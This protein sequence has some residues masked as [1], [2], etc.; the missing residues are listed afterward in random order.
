MFILL[1]QCVILIN[2]QQHVLITPNQAHPLDIEPLIINIRIPD[3]VV[4][5]Q[6]NTND[7]KSL[8]YQMLKCQQIIFNDPGFSYQQYKEN[9]DVHREILAKYQ[10]M[11]EGTQSDYLQLTLKKD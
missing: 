3:V 2:S 9:I 1:F 5:E 7:C 10:T 8:I 11:C 6:M 4:C